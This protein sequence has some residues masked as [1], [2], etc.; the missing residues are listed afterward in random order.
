MV[1]K[2]LLFRFDTRVGVAEKRTGPGKAPNKQICFVPVL[3]GWNSSGATLPALHCQAVRYYFQ[4]YTS[5]EE[6]KQRNDKCSYCLENQWALCV[7]LQI[8]DCCSQP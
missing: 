4:N 1:A 5:G 7:L 8:E 3:P 2:Y 6:K